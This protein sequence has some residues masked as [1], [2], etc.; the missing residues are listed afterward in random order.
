MSALPLIVTPGDPIGIG[1]EVTVRALSEA[2]VGSVVVVGSEPAF[3]AA[4]GEALI[5]G[6]SGRIEFLTPPAD[7]APAVEW[8]SVVYAAGECLA[9]R[10]RGLVTGPIHK[11]RLAARGFPFRGHTDLLAD[12]GGGAEVVMAFVGGSVRVALATVHVPLREV[13]DLITTKRVLSVVCIA[14]RELETR[15][16]IQRPRITVCGLNPH[17]GEQGLLGTEDES[18]IRP[19]VQAAVGLGISARGPI[20]AE[21]AFMHPQESDLIVAMY[22]DQG[23]VPLK[24]VDFGRTVNWTLGLPFLRTS[25][26]HG[27]ADALVGTGLAKAE[28]MLAALRL[29]NQLSKE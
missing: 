6:S 14:A 11:A 21:E 4:G 29:A 1:P 20:S 10:A 3:F 9:G 28:S 13:P 16:G 5:R 7:L 24:R 15:L 27:T 25:V 22:H 2:D 17:A 8:A 12:L 18:S 26:D 19:A 23:L